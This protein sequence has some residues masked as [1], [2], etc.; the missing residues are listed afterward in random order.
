MDGG[1]FSHQINSSNLKDY[2]CY[3]ILIINF[4]KWL[5]IFIISCSPYPIPQLFLVLRTEVQ[6]NE[7]QMPL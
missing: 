7:I 4:P 2:A 6:N 5:A 1:I 3:Y